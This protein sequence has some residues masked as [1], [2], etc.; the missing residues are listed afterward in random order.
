MA[1][2]MQ[3]LHATLNSMKKV[4][5]SISMMFGPIPNIYSLVV[6]IHVMRTR[7]NMCMHKKIPLNTQPHD[8]TSATIAWS[9]PFRNFISE[10]SVSYINDVVC[11]L[12][13]AYLGEVEHVMDCPRQVLIMNYQKMDH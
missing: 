5:S 11:S 4:K 1:Q 6:Y 12:Q 9:E 13:K 3:S 2:T 8:H 7:N 10:R